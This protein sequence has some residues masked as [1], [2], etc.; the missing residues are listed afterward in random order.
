M[1]EVPSQKPSSTK[2]AKPIEE[3]LLLMPS[4]PKFARLKPSVITGVARTADWGIFEVRLSINRRGDG[5]SG[6]VVKMSWGADK[7]NF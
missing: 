3:S 7:L 5:R 1:E 2:E 4:Q 6:T